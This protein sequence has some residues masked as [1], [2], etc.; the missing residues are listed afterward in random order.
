[1]VNDTFA[2]LNVAPA[3]YE[4]GRVTTPGEPGEYVLVVFARWDSG[5]D[6]SFAGYFDIR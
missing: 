3:Q 2:W 4:S 6:Y 1:M 5:G